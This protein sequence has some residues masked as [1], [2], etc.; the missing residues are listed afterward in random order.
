MSCDYDEPEDEI[1]GLEP[2]LEALRQIRQDNAALM[3]LLEAQRARMKH[4]A[5]PYGSH[6]QFPSDA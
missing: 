3:L 2:I 6:R 1:S 4:R 5:P